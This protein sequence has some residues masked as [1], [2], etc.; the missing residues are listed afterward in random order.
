MIP[1]RGKALPVLQADYES[2]VAVPIPEALRVLRLARAIARDH[3]VRPREAVAAAGGVVSLDCSGIRSLLSTKHED[4]AN[5]LLK[6]VLGLFR[7]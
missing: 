3:R 6:L 4:L 2:Y 7:L 5:G 1:V